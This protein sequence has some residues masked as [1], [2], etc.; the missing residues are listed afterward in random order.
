[1]I[2]NFRYRKKPVVIEAFKLGHDCIPDWF[3]TRV[4]YGDVTLYL[5][6]GKPPVNGYADI[7]TLEGVMRA[8]CG[9]YVICGISG[10]IYPCKADIFDMTY[11]K[12]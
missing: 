11:E 6:G 5:E 8:N 9:D 12:V 10:E 3:M 1:M 7:K 4:S 2:T